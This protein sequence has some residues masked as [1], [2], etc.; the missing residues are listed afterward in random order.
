MFKQPA[1]AGHR[2]QHG[3]PEHMPA[4]LELRR[5]RR[6]Q[7]ARLHQ[8]GVRLRHD[9]RA[10][11]I[12][13][14]VPHA[15]HTP[16]RDDGGAVRRFLRLDL[17]VSAARDGKAA[18]RRIEHAV[19]DDLVLADVPLAHGRDRGLHRHTGKRLPD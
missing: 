8:V 5:Q 14:E 1:A 11:G 6:N 18:L 3:A 13:G 4:R 2:A 10:A 15:A 12:A 17:A 16:R 9:D 19:S 7:R